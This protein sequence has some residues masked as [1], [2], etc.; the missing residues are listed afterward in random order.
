MAA[1]KRTFGGQPADE[2]LADLRRFCHADTTTHVVGDTHGSAQLEGRRQVWLRIQMNLNAS[3]AEV[4][5]MVAA[6][7]ARVEGESG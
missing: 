7:Q 5:A 3:E 2:V 4:S 6:A 1:Y